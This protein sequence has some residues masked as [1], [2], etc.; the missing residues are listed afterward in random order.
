MDFVMKIDDMRSPP[1]M[2]PFRAAREKNEVTQVRALLAKAA[3]F[4]PKFRVAIEGERQG[5]VVA[6]VAT[7]DPPLPTSHSFVVEFN[8]SKDTIEICE[9]AS[10]GVTVSNEHP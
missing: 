6:S 7:A 5:K 1:Q 2:K 9:K 4:E 3:W 10:R 8:R